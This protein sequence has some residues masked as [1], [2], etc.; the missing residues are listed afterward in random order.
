MQNI[1][2]EAGRKEALRSLG[3]KN[4]KASGKSNQKASGI[5]CSC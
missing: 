3:Q 2:R 5:Q 4:R 1:E